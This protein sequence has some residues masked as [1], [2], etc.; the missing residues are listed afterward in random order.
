MESK[1]GDIFVCVVVAVV[2]LGIFA[3][4]YNKEFK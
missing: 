2:G 3:V 1:M 4:M